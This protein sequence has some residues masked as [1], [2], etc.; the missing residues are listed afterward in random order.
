MIFFPD[1][2]TRTVGLVINEHVFRLMEVRRGPFYH[3]KLRLQRYAETRIPDGIV[4]AG[5]FK[6]PDE[7]AARLKSLLKKAFGR[8]KTCGVVVSLPETR[9][10]IKVINVTKPATLEEVP[11]AV[12]AEASLHI[13]VPIQ[14]LY[15]DWQ[16]VGDAKAV[17]V[18]KPMSVAIAAAP[19]EIVDS[20]AA[21][22][23]MA[24]LIPV[25]FEIEAQS[26]VRCVIPIHD[27]PAK[28]YGII[29]FGATRSSFIVYDHGTIQ[30]TVSIP[31][32]GDMLTER[33]GA[34]LNV[35]PEEAE[36][37]KRQCGV[38]AHKCGTQIWE[39]MQ[40]FLAEISERIQNAMEFYRDHFTNGRALD[41]LLLC[42]GGAN[43]ARMDEL[44]TELLKINVRKADPQVNLDA[45]HSNLPVEV[46]L[47]STTAVGLALRQPLSK[48]KS[49]KKL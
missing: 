29:D 14:D 23:E 16:P 20:Y 2:T 5:V 49:Q 28:S 19:K 17:P 27:D 7:A 40:P 26:I 39:I 6:K 43:M 10:F 25:A 46:M 34:A 35:S 41:E 32:S 30:F 22:L 15:L 12:S 44:L 8:M 21:T 4:V 33:I 1:P 42:G 38:D 45:K 48:G 36:R 18:G 24:G 11:A 37:T 9:T 13:P 3:R 47:S 31:L